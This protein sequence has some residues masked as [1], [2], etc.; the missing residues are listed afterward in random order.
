M[1][2]TPAV[3]ATVARPPAADLAWTPRPPPDWQL[4]PMNQADAPPPGSESSGRGVATSDLQSIGR[5]SSN[6]IEES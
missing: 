5:E 1:P 6:R 2:S 4:R 3:S